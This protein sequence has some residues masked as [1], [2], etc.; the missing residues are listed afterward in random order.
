MAGTAGPGSLAESRVFRYEDMPLR[1]SANGSESRAVTNGI[2]RSGETMNMHESMQPAGAEPVALHVIHHTE[3][4]CIQQGVVTFDHL[5]AS[6]KQMSEQ[7]GPGG[8]IYVAAETNHRVRN[9]GTEPAKYFVIA[10]GGDAK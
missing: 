10:I 4:I 1:T 8:V 7:V 2:L 9:A 6:G 5:D 3:F